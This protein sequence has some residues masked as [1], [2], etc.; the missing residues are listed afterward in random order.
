MSRLRA[1]GISAAVTLAVFVYLALPLLREMIGP[2]VNLPVYAGIALLA[3]A[4]TWAVVRDFSSDPETDPAGM[5][6]RREVDDETEEEGPRPA[7]DVE[8]EMEQLREET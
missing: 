1:V 5:T 2:V 4:V 8:T 7:P 3:G 6:A